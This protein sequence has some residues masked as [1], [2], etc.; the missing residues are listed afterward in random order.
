MVRILVVNGPNLNLLGERE[1]DVYRGTSLKEIEENMRN[2][3]RDLE[4]ELEFFQSNH[5]GAIIDKLHEERKRADFLIINPGGL[6]HYSV[7]LH[8]AIKAAGIPAIEV[9]LSNIYAREGFR[10]NSLIAP[11]VIGGIFG[12]GPTSYLLAL[13]AALHMTGATRNG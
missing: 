7:S 12:L 6:T 9:H 13:E 3:V 5:E 4:V 1:P 2:R 10:R 8:D 11:A